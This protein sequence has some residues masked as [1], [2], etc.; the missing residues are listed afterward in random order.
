MTSRENITYVQF[1]LKLAEILNNYESDKIHIINIVIYYTINNI[2]IRK[3]SLNDSE[4]TVRPFYS[5]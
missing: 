3:E 4:Y 1:F 5:Q 2:D